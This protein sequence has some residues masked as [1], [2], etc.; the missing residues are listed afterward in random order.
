MNTLARR[1]P[2]IGFAI[3]LLCPSIWASGT[4]VQETEMTF[5][6][7]S[8]FDAQQLGNGRVIVDIE[9][10]WDG[11]QVLYSGIWGEV[12]GASVTGIVGVP[13]PIW[14]DFA[15][16]KAAL[17]GRWLDVE[18]GYFGG[19]KLWSGIFVEDGDDYAFELRTTLAEAAF[20]DELT[21]NLWAG[22]QIIDFEAYTENG[23]L[24]FGA[25]WTDDPN[26]P[27]TSL[28]YHLTFAQV[29]DLVN[30]VFPIDPASG[31]SPKPGMAGRVIDFE[32]YFSPDHG[33]TRYALIMSCHPGGGLFLQVAPLADLDADDA[34]FTNGSTRLVDL[35][36][37]DSG[38]Q[39]NYLG[40]WSND[41][42]SLNEL[43]RVT[44]DIDPQPISPDLQNQ[45][46]LFEAGLSGLPPGTLGFYARNVRTDQSIAYNA[47]R[48]FYMASTSKVPMHIRMWQLDESDDLD[49]INDMMSYSTNALDGNPWYTNDR[50]PNGALGPLDF[51]LDFSLAQLDSFMVVQSD[52]SATS[53][54]LEVQ[55]GRSQMNEWLSSQAGFGVGFHPVTGITDLDRIIMWQGQV[56]NFP[57]A[58]SYWSIPSWNWEHF[59]RGGVDT[60]GWLQ[61]FVGVGNPLPSWSGTQGRLRYFRM[62]LNSVEPRAF[63]LMQERLVEGDFF[64]TAARTDQ[65]LAVFGGNTPLDDAVDGTVILPGFP[66]A[67]AGEL[68]T[69]LTKN[70]GKGR[71]SSGTLVVN[72][73]A[74]FQKGPDTITMCVF[75][76]GNSITN[77]VIRSQFMT[78]IGYLLYSELISDLADGGNHQASDHSV[79]PGQKWSILADV[80]NLRG[81]DAT[82][83]KVRF[84]ASTNPIITDNDTLLGEYQ[85]PVDHPGN[86]GATVGLFLEDFPNLPAGDYYIGWIIDAADEVGEWDDDDSSN[87]VLML[88]GVGS[89]QLIEVWKPSVRPFGF[90]ASWP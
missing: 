5:A 58:L 36:I 2:A 41:V 73:T 56:N 51:G 7:L 54:L 29:D 82:P 21:D 13:G 25:I 1:L 15:D 26:Q 45:I 33:E 52:N 88:T 18:V 46:D 30:P 85:T 72:D 79:Y 57:T 35:D 63:G 28:Y 4:H 75:T 3:S 60:F 78:P 80:D 70:G 61:N 34:G 81:G 19:Q 86:S 9:M 16:D 22:R 23:D 27:R 67:P 55:I 38:G 65:C 44:E 71:S 64:N 87:T 40:V 50:D 90:L 43:P 12:P 47:S 48:P 53:M 24:K 20:E 83:Y 42:K 89:P 49:L 31:V 10:R 68:P 39:L 11:S 17:D 69:T 6:Q 8:A 74:L 14:Q 84:Y 76:Q 59:F 62:G 32:R 77:T 37:F 66:P